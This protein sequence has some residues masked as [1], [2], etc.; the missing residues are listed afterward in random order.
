[1]NSK[2]LYMQR[3]A[4]H[5]ELREKEQLKLVQDVQYLVFQERPCGNRPI[6]R[7]QFPSHRC[8]L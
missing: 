8:C 5:N 2:V 6:C 1:M 4:D 7:A 3:V